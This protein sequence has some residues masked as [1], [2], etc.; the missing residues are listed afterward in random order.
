MVAYK[1]PEGSKHKYKAEEVDIEFISPGKNESGGGAFIGAI[2]SIAPTVVKM[3][4]QLADSLI[5]RR[6]KSFTRE[7]MRFQ[8]NL[9]AGRQGVIPD[10]DFIRTVEIDGAKHTALEISFRTR[11]ISN[12]DSLTNVFTYYVEKI[13]LNYTSA[14]VKKD[15][16]VDYTIT[17]EPV[18]YLP[19]DKKQTVMEIAPLTIRS[20]GG[21]LNEYDDDRLRYRT[22]VLMIP[23]DAC[24]LGLTVTVVESNPRVVN[25][26]KFRESWDKYKT[27]A[28]S[29]VVGPLVDRF[30]SDLKK[31]AED[32]QKSA[33]ENEQNIKAEERLWAIVMSR[34]PLND[35]E[36]RLREYLA[37]YPLGAH[38][39]EA[40]EALAAIESRKAKN[41]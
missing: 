38:S 25:I 15:D 27:D 31:S 2:S 36:A 9:D 5:A 28:E 11:D 37:A 18:F 26:K 12:F 24:F 23:R 32:K 6:E 4:F 34:K 41:N 3:G 30:M 10:F 7:Y 19:G 40:I 20:V 39:G 1:L 16:R 8:S 33:E 22:E 29:K 14:R 35:Y 21:G 13:A 17:L